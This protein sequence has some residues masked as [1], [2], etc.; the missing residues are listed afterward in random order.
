[1]IP[2]AADRNPQLPPHHGAAFSQHAASPTQRGPQI[3]PIGR[4]FGAYLEWT[5]E[6]T[7]SMIQAATGCSRAT[8]AKIAKRLEAAA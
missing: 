2:K 1:M 5:S 4:S 6:N 3:L 8:I 7:G